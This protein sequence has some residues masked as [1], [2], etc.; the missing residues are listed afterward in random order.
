YVTLTVS[1]T[2]VGMDA[3]TRARVFEPFFTTKPPGQGTGL[4]L[5]IVAEVA[6]ERHGF[7]RVQSEPGRGTTFALHLPRLP[8]DAAVPPEPQPAPEEPPPSRATVLVVEDDPAGRRLFDTILRTQGYT[9]L[10]TSQGAE[11]LE[12]CRQHPGRIDLLIAD[13]RL[14]QMSGRDVARAVA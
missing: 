14:P 2:G 6:A 1:D 7:V 11:A 12:L 4:G 9:L 3:A 13:L 5:A 10:L 8:E